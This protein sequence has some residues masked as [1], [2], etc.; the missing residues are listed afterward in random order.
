MCLPS[1]QILHM[2]LPARPVLAS[3]SIDGFMPFNA[4]GRFKLP[5]RLI[6]RDAQAKHHHRDGSKRGSVHSGMA[7]E[8]YVT[9]SIHGLLN[10]V[11]TPHEVSH[12]RRWMPHVVKQRYPAQLGEA[13]LVYFGDMSVLARHDQWADVERGKEL[14]RNV[15]LPAA[16]EIRTPD[17]DS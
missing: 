4:P 16:P 12:P 17:V 6:Q 15:S 2:V 5:D 10:F 14:C 7:V 1:R 3:A 9:P 8:D 11:A 13:Y